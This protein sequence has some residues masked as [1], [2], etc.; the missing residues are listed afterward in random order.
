MV[1]K[2]KTNCNHFS[3]EEETQFLPV[4]RAIATCLLS[5]IGVDEGRRGERQKSQS[6]SQ[7]FHTHA[8]GRESP[9]SSATVDGEETQKWREPGDRCTP[10]TEK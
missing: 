8:R 5:P 1:L 6:L 4:E 2:T 7:I 9:L 3:P 10:S